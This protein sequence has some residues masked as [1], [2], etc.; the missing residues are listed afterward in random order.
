[1]LVLPDRTTHPVITMKI[2]MMIL[3]TLK[4]CI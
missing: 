1:M 3:N 4:N 2:K